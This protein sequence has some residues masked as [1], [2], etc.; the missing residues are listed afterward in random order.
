MWF[1]FFYF[2]RQLKDKYLYTE[3]YNNQQNIPEL[4]KAILQQNANVFSGPPITYLQQGNQILLYYLL[5]CTISS[6][7][8]IKIFI[9]FKII[10]IL[11]KYK[12]N[13]LIT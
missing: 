12:F 13:G 8:V 10:I 3:H 9:F 6:I 7:I 11:P 1:F 2:Y 5:L 4:L